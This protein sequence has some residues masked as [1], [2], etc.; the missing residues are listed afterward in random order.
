MYF[1]DAQQ[2]WGQYLGSDQKPEDFDAFWDKGKAMIDALP[3][4]F[5]LIPHDIFSHV[6]NG[7]D[8]FFTSHDGDRIHCQLVMPKDEEKNYPTQI[9]FHGYHGSSG[10]WGDKIG[11]AA[12]GYCV[13]AMDVR[14]QGG[15]SEDSRKTTGGTLKGHIIR[16]VEDGPDELFYRHVYLDIYHVTRIACHLP[17]VNEDQLSVYGASQGGALAI[18]CAAL[19]PSIKQVFVLY[20]FLSDY[21]EA[22]RLDV[23]QSA[24]E[25]LAYWFR[26][27]DPSHANEN[28]FFTTLDY[29]DIQYLAS[30][31]KGDILWGIGLADTICPP[32]TQFAVFNQ[33][34]G[35]KEMIA[36]PEYGHEYIPQ[37]GD[38]VRKKLIGGKVYE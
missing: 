10:D 11:L 15:L 22:F 27:R 37:F 19:F 14:G 24:Y 30:R 25:E 9:Q 36:F 6:A 23:E 21:R 13:I 12:E 4:N 7:Y 28:Q 18:V 3:I 34:S 5:E 32:K 2:L 33:L 29:I 16:G 8:L 35:T 1:R 26:F 17:Q 38:I 31:V 20:P